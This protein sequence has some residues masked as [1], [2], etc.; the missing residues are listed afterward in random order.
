LQSQVA[1]SRRNPQQQARLHLEQASTASGL[2]KRLLI[3]HSSKLVAL[4]VFWAA[5]QSPGA[6]GWALIGG[7]LL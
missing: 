5:I 2:L 6:L 1:D 4:A 3:L 7:A